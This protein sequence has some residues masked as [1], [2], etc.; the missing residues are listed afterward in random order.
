[1]YIE[2]NST[3]WLFK[4]IKLDNNY[5]NTMWF[6][7]SDAQTNFFLP[8]AFA[9]YNQMSYQRKDRG[10][11]R[12]EA[13][14]A[15][16]YSVNYMIFRNTSFENKLFYA[17]VD[18]VEYVNN[19]T[20][21][22]YYSLDVIQTYM[23][24]WEL[25]QCLIERQHSTTDVAGDNLEA[26]GLDIGDAI[27]NGLP[28]V[29]TYAEYSI[30]MGIATGDNEDM[31]NTLSALAD[32]N[33]GN[34]NTGGY[35]LV[36]GLPTGV[37]IFRFDVGTGET[38]LF[39][40]RQVIG[41]LQTQNQIDSV[42]FAILA[43]TNAMKLNS[44]IAP[45]RTKFSVSKPTTLDGYTP[46]NKKLFTYPYC[47]LKESNDQNESIDFRYE[48][49]GATTDFRVDSI[50]SSTP[51]I[52]ARPEHYDGRDNNEEY[53][54][55]VSGFPMVSYA[56]DGYRAWL[57]MNYDNVEL[58]RAIAGREYD[59]NAREIAVSKESIKGNFAGG[60]A[61]A[62]IGLFAGIASGSPTVATR[63][64][65]NMGQSALNYDV[66]NQQN[67]LAGERN[68]LS[69]YSANQR[70]NISESVAK[71]LPNSPNVGGNATS[72][73][74]GRKGFYFRRMSIRRRFAEKVDKYFTMFGY[75]QNMV[76]T[77]NLHVRQNFTYIKTCGSNISGNIP[78][79][80]KDVIDTIFDR[81]IRFWVNYNNFE[82]YSVPNE[83][84]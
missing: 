1:M 58:S 40:Y 47:Y 41:Y 65:V 29:Y 39:K 23:F 36:N 67:K 18:K 71:K 80:D 35:A 10:V 2:P 76:G 19:E 75:A 59:L 54:L 30:F 81:G 66:A 7:N 17:F 53:S 46:V 25:H 77:P 69:L 13:R 21:N 82:D 8:K 28:S 52:I 61:N 49:F 37:P 34:V 68:E 50:I 45:Y 9:I 20:I 48:L 72:V 31:F 5:S 64:L 12:I 26:E 24:D 15:D 63:S 78:Q 27:N 57:A 11:I 38:P 33:S 84:I 32:E 44:S 62:G 43:P 55:S 83:I 79:D 6:P 16:A 22:I 73:A 70:A 4:D 74:M 51:E 56:N 14:I 42:A 60:L 3:L